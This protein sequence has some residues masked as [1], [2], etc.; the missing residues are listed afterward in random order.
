MHLVVFQRC[1]QLS[2]L[3][4]RP[5]RP[6][7]QKAPFSGFRSIH[8]SVLVMGA[9]RALDPGPTPQY[10]AAEC[11]RPAPTGWLDWRMQQKRAPAMCLGGAPVTCNLACHSA[12]GMG[13][14]HTSTGEDRALGFSGKVFREGG[15]SMAVV[16]Y[17]CTVH[18]CAE[19]VRRDFSTHERGVF[20]QLISHQRGTRMYVHRIGYLAKRTHPS[21]ESS[22]RDGQ[23]RLRI[24]LLCTYCWVFPGP[25]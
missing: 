7:F 8:Q 22:C 16:N 19:Y 5:F 21:L 3:T 6:A 23:T 1:P 13:S 2:A 25:P 9:V 14:D 10:Q 17:V 24:S 15:C 4:G 12:R 11:A 20:E 18:Y